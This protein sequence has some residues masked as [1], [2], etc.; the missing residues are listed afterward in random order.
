MREYITESLMRMSYCF[1]YDNPNF[2]M[3]I[4]NFS[5]IF[6]FA[7]I[8]IVSRQEER[9]TGSVNVHKPGLEVMSAKVQRHYM[10]VLPTRLSLLTIFLILILRTDMYT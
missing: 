7:F 4:H 5:V 2:N 8:M 10:S 3:R 1:T 6:F 9:G